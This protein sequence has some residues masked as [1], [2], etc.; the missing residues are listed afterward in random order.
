MKA[1]R[2]KRS[3]R[4]A[5]PLGITSDVDPVLAQ[6]ILYVPHG[7]GWRTYISTSSAELLGPWPWA[8]LSRTHPCDGVE[9][10]LSPT[11]DVNLEDL[12][13]IGSAL[14]R[15]F[16]HTEGLSWFDH[17]I[18]MKFGVDVYHHP[19]NPAMGS[20]VICAER[21]KLLILR[22]EDSDLSKSRAPARLLGMT[23]SRLV[24]PIKRPTELTRPCITLSN[25]SWC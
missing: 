9:R 8:P 12:E 22:S 21:L 16:D 15:A 3:S 19:F 2:A 25:G 11:P 24:A 18:G 13:D 14:I 1:T 23:M 17:E 10:C 5:K 7:S 6:A 20:M 4:R